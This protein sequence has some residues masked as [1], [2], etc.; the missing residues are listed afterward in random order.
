MR[1]LSAVLALLATLCPVHAAENLTV[2]PDLVR[3]LGPRLSAAPVDKNG[4]WNFDTWKA[5]H[6]D[7]APRSVTSQSG[8][9]D[10][11][12][13]L[14]FVEGGQPRVIR[15]AEDWAKRRQVLR[16][17]L[18]ELVGPLPAKGPPLDAK[19]LSEEKHG[20][21]LVRKVRYTAEKGDDIPVY[22]FFPQ[23]TDKPLPAVICLHQTNAKLGSRE[24]S[25]LAGDPTLAFARQLAER[26]Y[27]T[28][29]PDAICFGER[30]RAGDPYQH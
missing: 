13:L 24:P 25:G 4:T 20:Q 21:L 12:P 17:V 18:V 23:G 9:L 26:G 5:R 2:L 16:N 19:L 7:D 6:A 11:E 27:V 1:W 10:L 8:K 29:A 22:C 3:L 15:S 14:S 30:Y 28:L